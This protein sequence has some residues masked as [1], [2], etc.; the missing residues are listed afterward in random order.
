MCH[1]KSRK[2]TW[3]STVLIIIITIIIIIISIISTSIST[4]TSLLDCC[5]VFTYLS[6]QSQF[7]EKRILGC[8]TL[9]FLGFWRSTLSK[10]NPVYRRLF[11]LFPQELFTTHVTRDKRQEREDDSEQEETKL[12]C[13]LFPSSCLER[14]KHQQ[15]DTFLFDGFSES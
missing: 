2:K 7:E 11:F 8:C 13:M 1:L 12:L 14:G 3:N 4:H 6:T 15:E 5:V 10:K 9:F